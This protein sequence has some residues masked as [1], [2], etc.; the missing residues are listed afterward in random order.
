VPPALPTNTQNQLVPLLSP[1]DNELVSK[2]KN[3]MLG[4]LLIDTGVIVPDT[5]TT[6]LKLQE[7][8]SNGLLSTDQAIDAVKKSRDETGAIEVAALIK[9]LSG[10][11][12]KDK[13]T[14]IRRITPLLGEILVKAEVINNALLLAIL[15]LQEVVRSGA[16]TQAEAC[17][18]FKREL[19]GVPRPQKQVSLTLTAKQQEGIVDLLVQ[20]GLLTAIDKETAYLLLKRH[21]GRIDNILATAGKVSKK[22]FAAAIEC[23]RLLAQKK[24]KLEKAM[25]ALNYCERSR[26]GLTEAIADLGWHDEDL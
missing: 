17:Q 4:Q 25:I 7:M 18:A 3:Y 14:S 12:D 15:K 23:Q 2:Q 19:A 24:L 5:L 1:A 21:G 11:A 8:I 26:V 13:D 22:T 9:K 6:I 10:A 20:A 16:M